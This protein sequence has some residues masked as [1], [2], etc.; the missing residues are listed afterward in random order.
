MLCQIATGMH[1]TYNNFTEEL[2]VVSRSN[3][4]VVGEEKTY[5]GQYGHQ[6]HMEHFEFLILCLIHHSENR[7]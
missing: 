1:C 5:D 3:I 4:R 7:E 6:H 2:L